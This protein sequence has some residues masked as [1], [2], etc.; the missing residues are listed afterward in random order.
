MTQLEHSQQSVAR[1]RR[2]NR[3]L[4][5]AIL[6][7]GALIMLLPLGI[8]LSQNSQTLVTATVLSEQ[9]HSQYEV[10]THTTE[11]VCNATVRFAT[12]SGQVIRTTVSGAFPYDF[13]HPA[14]Q[15]ATISLRYD[16]SNPD[17]PV[18]QSS[19]LSLTSL[20][21]LLG[22]GAVGTAL[23]IRGVVRAER[24]AEN[25]VRRR[26]SQTVVRSDAPVWVKRLPYVLAVILILLLL[27]FYL[28]PR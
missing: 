8:F 7:L 14:G 22:L 6:V 9:C 13:S 18:P 25:V 27:I 20:L 12:R 28:V 10:A 24:I 16:S 4:W 21:V 15:P 19:Y 2:Q 17:Q 3:I 1:L 23:G 5:T 26:M 11:T